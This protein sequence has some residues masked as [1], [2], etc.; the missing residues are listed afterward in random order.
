MLIPSVLLAQ[1]NEVMRNGDIFSYEVYKGFLRMD[2]QTLVNLEIFNNNADGG[3][4]GS[5]FISLS[6]SPC[7]KL[8]VYFH[9]RYPVQISR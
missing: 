5:N 3:P 6:L 1:L 7:F 8:N 9:P 4:S 2:G